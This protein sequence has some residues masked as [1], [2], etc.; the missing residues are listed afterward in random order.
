MDSGLTTQLGATVAAFVLSSS[1]GLRAYLPIFALGLA[2]ALGFVPREALG[3]SYDMLTNPVVLVVLGALSILEIV[4]DKVPAVDHVSDAIHTV[5][6]PI[7]GALIFAGTDNFVSDH[8]RLVAAVLGLALA[9]GVHATKALARPAVTATTAG[10]G[11][12]VV[13]IMEDVLAIAIIAL[14]VIVP[15]VAF[16]LLLIVAV[17]FVLVVRWGWRKVRRRKQ[18]K[19]ET[20]VGSTRQG[21]TG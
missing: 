7:M 10:V 5:I 1:S 2:G 11:N 20:K 3:P 9:G 6:R 19:Q 13:S 18:K 4:A 21:A 14:A 15:V 12:P 8:N 16:L 17:V